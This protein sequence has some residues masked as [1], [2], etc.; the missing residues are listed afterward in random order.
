MQQTGG[1]IKTPAHAAGIGAAAAVNPVAHREAVNQIGD[2]AVAIV[3]RQVVQIALQLQQFPA[4]QDLVDGHLLG[5]I[6]HELAH[7][8]WLHQTVNTP[9]NN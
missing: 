5:H 9:N 2:A 1:Q 6:A 4:T 3:P 8:S 7:F